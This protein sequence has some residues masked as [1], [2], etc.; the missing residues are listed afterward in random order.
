MKKM[1]CDVCRE[2]CEHPQVICQAKAE[3]VSDDIARQVADIFKILGDSTRIKILQILSRRELCVCDLAAVLNMGQSAVSHQLR[4][5]R[6]ARLVKYRRDG[7][8]A[9]YSLDDGHIAT[10]LHQGLSHAEHIEK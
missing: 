6:S 5:L 8:K 4:L 3:L 10:L 9:W 7:K 1:Q 2:H